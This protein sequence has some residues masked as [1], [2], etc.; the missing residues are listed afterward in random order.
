MAE[1]LNARGLNLKAEPPSDSLRQPH[2]PYTQRRPF[3]HTQPENDR[4]QARG[5]L[6]DQSK[7]G[8]TGPEILVDG[9]STMQEMLASPGWWSCAVLMT[10]F[11]FAQKREI[12]Y[13]SAR[14][15]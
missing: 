1:I 3:L 7:N 11:P 4:L 5:R 12:V 14:V 15:A 2:T 8:A 9:G 6:V 13:C 10:H